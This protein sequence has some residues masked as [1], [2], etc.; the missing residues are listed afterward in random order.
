MPD[1]LLVDFHGKHNPHHIFC[2]QTTRHRNLVPVS[3]AKQQ[4][5]TAGCQ[6][7]LRAENSSLH[8]PTVDADGVVTKCAPLAIMMESH[9][10]LA[11][12]VLACMGMGVLVLLLSARLSSFAVRHLFRETGVKLAIVSPRLHTV[13][14]DAASTL[15]GNSTCQLNGDG[16]I[17]IRPADEWGTLLQGTDAAGGRQST[18]AAQNTHFVSEQDHQVITLHSSGMSGLAGASTGA[19]A[20]G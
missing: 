4:S 11:I 10:G 12:Y 9:V 7:K 14:L 8:P 17:I 2:T 3:D 18:R 1:V 20:E 6:A 13:A 19:G 16:A 5:A 15:E